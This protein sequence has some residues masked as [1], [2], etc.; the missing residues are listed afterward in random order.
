MIQNIA[1]YKVQKVFNNSSE[2]I[3]IIKWPEHEKFTSIFIFLSLLKFNKLI[4]VY[5][6]PLTS[7]YVVRIL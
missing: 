6:E 3:P 5:Y 2:T 7:K 1:D 4:G